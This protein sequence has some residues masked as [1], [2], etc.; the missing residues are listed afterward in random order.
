MIH[1]LSAAICVVGCLFVGANVQAET[2]PKEPQE[3]ILR[4][5]RCLTMNSWQPSLERALA[6]LRHSSVASEVT[7]S[8]V[9]MRQGYGH[10]PHQNQV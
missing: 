9:G 7:L 8:Q 10:A 4:R 6:L 2:K 5:L 1:R 3:P